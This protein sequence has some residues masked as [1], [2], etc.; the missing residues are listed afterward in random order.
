[1]K[2]WLLFWLD[3]IKLLGILFK[4]IIWFYED[5]IRYQLKMKR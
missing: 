3:E 2:E 4:E 1:M 5:L